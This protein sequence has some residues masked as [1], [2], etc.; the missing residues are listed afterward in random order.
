MLRLVHETR[1]VSADA[2]VVQEALD[3]TSGR[4]SNVLVPQVLL[5]HALDL[6][7][8]DLINRLLNLLGSEAL[9]SGDKLAAN[10]LSNGSA[11]IKAEEERR[12]ELRLSTLNLSGRGAGRRTLPLL[13]GKV[14]EVIQVH[15][16]LTHEV[17][18]PETSVRVRGAEVHVGVSQVVGRDNVR[19]TARHKRGST[20]R[21]VPVAE[22][23]LEHKQGEV[24]GR[25]PA[26]TLDRDRDVASRLGVVTHT[27]LRADELSLG[28][29]RLAERQR[30]CR[31]GE[32][33]EVLLSILDKLLVLNTTS[34][35]KHHPV[36]RVLLADVVGQV[37]ALDRHD[38][39][40]GTK[41]GAAKA[42]ALERNSVKVVEDD[43]LREL[44]DLLLLAQ[45]HVALALDG[46]SLELRVLQDV[47]NN[48]NSLAHIV[49]ERLGVVDS[50]LTRSVR[51]QVSTE[52][53][54]LNLELVLR[55]VVRAWSA[56]THP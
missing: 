45:D 20:E 50:L 48:V 46:A 8:G 17:D 24:V 21:A 28:V 26:G 4:N 37:I 11:A 55:A 54:N 51:I 42:R 38:V 40:L 1:H 33:R 30:V 13:E 5:R 27:D 47:G 10:V 39:L 15:V 16:V 6:A 22:H 36:G 19:Q 2:V 3:T 12:L 34:T 32:R 23:G 25:A 9:A 7:R 18:T 14:Q 43:L 53:L 41:D 29:E 52:V 31:H 44:L 49:A 35:N 56:K